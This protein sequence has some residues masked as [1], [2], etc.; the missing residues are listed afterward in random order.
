[1]PIRCLTLTK[2]AARLACGLYFNCDEQFTPGHRFK[3]KQF[4][5][6]LASEPDKEAASAAEILPPA[7]TTNPDAVP[8]AG[9][10]VVD[11]TPAISFHAFA[12]HS[13]PSTLR[14]EGR[15]NGQPMLILVDS[16]S[17]HNFV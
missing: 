11:E 14:L 8:L 9:D 15:V 13:V 12:G 3:T 17:T 5:C 4:L 10:V 1:M 16:G 7:T 6:L 2:M